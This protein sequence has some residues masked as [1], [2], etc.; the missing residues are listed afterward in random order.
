MNRVKFY[1][2]GVA[3]LYLGFRL[4]KSLFEKLNINY[5]DLVLEDD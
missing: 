1:L 2:F 4:A 3:V 5:S